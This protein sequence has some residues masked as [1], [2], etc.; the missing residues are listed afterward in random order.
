MEKYIA[1]ITERVKRAR[2][3]VAELDVAAAIPPPIVLAPID[4]SIPSAPSAMDVWKPDA[5][6]CSS[7][8]KLDSV[9]HD[10]KRFY[11]GVPGQKFT[12]HVTCAPVKP[13]LIVCRIDGRKVA[14]RVIKPS[15]N[16][17][18]V[19]I[20]GF[21][22]DSGYFPFTFAPL[23]VASE[24]DDSNLITSVAGEVR[25]ILYS[26][27]E[28]TT[29]IV[30]PPADVAPSRLLLN[31]NV[32]DRKFYNNPGLTVQ[33]GAIV[34]AVD[35]KKV[36]FSTCT[37]CVELGQVVFFF[38]TEERLRLRGILPT[39]ENLI[40]NTQSVKNAKRAK[41][42]EFTTMIDI[43]GDKPIISRIKKEPIKVE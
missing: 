3:D 7:A 21:Y 25:V 29:E 24:S 18:T 22:V 23:L 19:V 36:M 28:T 34:T 9:D 15:Y 6:L 11:I 43:T 41:F 4:S 35:K 8:L 12:I 39:H 37:D 26:V 31:N 27:T 13:C 20:E 5:W 10:G 40:R 32:A 30:R 14:S 33:P 17:S 1:E 16:G 2:G 42:S 38:D